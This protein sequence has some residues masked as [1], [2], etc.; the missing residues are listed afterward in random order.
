M[1]FS[2]KEVVGIMGRGN[3]YTAGSE[4]LIHI[5]IRNHRNHPVCQRQ[6]QLFSYDTPYIFHP[7]GFTATA[8]SPKSVFRS[9]GSNLHK[10]DLPLPLPGK[11][12]ARRSLLAPH[13]NL[14]IGN[15]GITNRTPVNHSGTAVNQSPSYTG[16]QRSPTP[17][18]SNPRPW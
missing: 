8:I 4:F 2:Y 7:R 1:S 9:G 17:H 14:R 12:C 13:A 10:R 16:G 11:G 5:G 18:G 15:G 3:L 6:M